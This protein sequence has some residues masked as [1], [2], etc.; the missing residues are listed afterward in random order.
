MLMLTYFLIAIG[1]SFLCSI[2]E[3]VLLSI[4]A[5]HVEL[6]KQENENLG[7]EMQKQ[8][9]N[10]DFSIAAI[11]TLNTFAHTLG[12][13]GVGAEAAKL[14]G[15]EYMFHISAFLTILILVFS[16]IIPKTLGAYYWKSLSGFSTRTIKVLIFITYPLLIVLNKITNFITPEKKET[17]TK[18]EII[19]TANIAEENGV[20]KERESGMIENLLQ[21]HEIKARDIFTPRSVLFSVQKDDLINSFKEN[22]SL[23]LN[24]LKEYSRVPVYKDDIDDIIGVVISKEYFHEYIENN[25]EDKTKIIKPIFSVNE[26][27][28]ISKLIDLFLLKKSICLL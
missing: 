20:L 14:F 17:I 18:E 12:A 2:L 16:E 3:A 13:A 10:I 26:N 4:T 19:A 25:L 24:K 6:V 9:T 1:V 21:L 27:I 22:M 11:L 8:K 5:S 23:D 28:P 15:E 7:L